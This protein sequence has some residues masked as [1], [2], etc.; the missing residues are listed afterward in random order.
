M[1][2]LGVFIL[3]FH[4][5]FYVHD[6]SCVAFLPRIRQTGAFRCHFK[7]SIRIISLCESDKCLGFKVPAIR[8]EKILDDLLHCFTF[9]RYSTHRSI[10]R[11]LLSLDKRSNKMGK[12]ISTIFET[13]L[14]GLPIIAPAVGIYWG[15]DEVRPGKQPSIKNLF[16]HLLPMTIACTILYP[17]AV[18]WM[19]WRADKQLKEAHRRY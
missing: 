12:R 2:S 4:R 3:P 1:S 18:P 5:S 13:Y 10:N 16:V 14:K 15:F 8:W 9:E 7:S 11:M 19:L 17:V 6:D